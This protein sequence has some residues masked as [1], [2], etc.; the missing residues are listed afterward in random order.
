MLII[1]MILG[2][3]GAMILVSY[4]VGEIEDEAY[5][6]GYND[7]LKAGEE[8]GRCEVDQNNYGCIR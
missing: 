6:K 3:C 5:L 2:F 1:G 7:G 4:V 8:N